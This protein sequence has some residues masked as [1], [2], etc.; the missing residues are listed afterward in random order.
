MN[1]KF[2]H[3]KL[4]CCINN[5]MDYYLSYKMGIHPKERKNAFTIG[6][7]MHWGLENSTE[8]LTKFFKEEGNIY[9][10]ENYSLDQLQAEAMVH[11]FMYHK[12]EIMQ[13]VFRDYD[14]GNQL[15]LVDE[16]SV[17]RELPIEAELSSFTH[18]EEP[19]LFNGIIDLLYLTTKGFV[20]LDYKSS[21]QIP[22]WNKYTDQLYRY[23]YQLNKNFPNVPV[24]KIGIINM[25]KS[26]IKKKL[27]ETDE[28]YKKRFF[29]QYEDKNSLLVNVHMFDIS[30]LD[31]TK[32]NEYIE[33]LSRQADVAD[34]YDR[35]DNY[36]INL[37]AANGQNGSYK[38]EYLE[39]YNHSKDAYKLY[40]IYDTIYDEGVI[41][42]KRDCLPLDMKVIENKNILN[43]YTKFVDEYKAYLN[44]TKEV[45]IE[46]FLKYLQDKYICDITLLSKYMQTY[47]YME[48]LNK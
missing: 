32:M 44:S 15:K 16:N 45:D 40:D 21:S 14:N 5:P 25:V 39:I 13:E 6:S 28:E 10:K 27:N 23:V 11:G 35:T 31:K 42:K 26:R 4:S 9:Q 7:A 33:N 34:N 19:Y 17:W 48:K 29:A 37:A 43:K 3:S 47:Q 22:D 41:L 12:K 20:L 36:Y 38:S 1:M 24:Y 18:P 30:S 46:E 2:S 8:D